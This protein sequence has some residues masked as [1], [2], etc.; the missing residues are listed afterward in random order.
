MKKKVIILGAGYGGIFAAAHLCKENKHVSVSLI[1]KNP[2]LQ[3]LQQ[4]PYIIS[5][6]KRQEDITVGIHELFANEMQTGNLEFV[7]AVVES[8]DLD[9]KTVRASSSQNKHEIKEY[10]YDYLVIS[11]GSETQYF[12]IAGAKENSLPF[13][14]VQD[15]LEIQERISS[16][17]KNSVVII[18]GAVPRVSA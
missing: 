9:N 3:L 14:S 7:E 12:D 5:G 8:I 6:S 16:L 2:Y 15:A 1:D 17:P 10:E 18:G 4:I 13:R 11:L